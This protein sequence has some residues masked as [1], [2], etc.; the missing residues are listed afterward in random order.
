[1]PNQIKINLHG[2]GSTQSILIV[3]FVKNL[4]N[5][6]FAVL[7]VNLFGFGSARPVEDL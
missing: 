2:K 3:K 7:S 5:L 4:F 1:M 6:M